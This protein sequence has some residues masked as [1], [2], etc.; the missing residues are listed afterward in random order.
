MGRTKTLQHPEQF[1]KYQLIAELGRSRLGT[2]YKAKIVGLEGF[3]KIVRVKAIDLAFCQ[4]PNLIDPLIAGTQRIVSLSHVNI[5][6]IFDLGQES[7]LGQYYIASEFVLGFDLARSH[8]LFKELEGDVPIEIYARIIS[9][10]AK[11]LDYAHRRKDYNFNSLN[12]AHLNLSPENVLLSFDG[13]VKVNDFGI[14]QAKR[15]LETLDENE[16]IK[17]FKYAAPEIAAGEIGTQQ[18]DIFSLGLMLYELVAGQHPYDLS[19]VE[20][21]RQSAMAA[22][23]VAI[24]EVVDI[25]RA[26][27]TIIDSMIVSNPFGRPDSAADVFEELIAFIYTSTVRTDSKTISLLMQEIRRK[28]RVIDNALTSSSI[29]E[30]SIAD[31]RILTD[32]TMTRQLPVD[33]THGQLP[34]HKLK[35]SFSTVQP[36]LPGSLEE[37]FRDVRAGKGKAVIVSGI[38]GSGRTFLPDRLVDALGWRGN[39]NAYLANV[40]NDDAF[41]PFSSVGNAILSIVAEEP[42]LE[43]AFEKCKLST[44]EKNLINTFRGFSNPFASTLTTLSFDQKVEYLSNAVLKIFRT[45][46]IQGPLVVIFDHIDNVD[47]VSRGVLRLIVEKIPDMSLMLVM[48]SRK[49]DSV[50]EWFDRGNPAALENIHVSGTEPPSLNAL[51]DLTP[52]QARILSTIALSGRFSGQD[53]ITRVATGS[54]NKEVIQTLREL[55]DLSYLRIPKPGTFAPGIAHLETWPSTLDDKATRIDAE[56]MT[57]FTIY[58]DKKG[59][60]RNPTL[61]RYF[62]HAGDQNQFVQFVQHYIWWLKKEGWTEIALLFLDHAILLAEQHSIFGQNIIISFLISRAELALDMSR[63]SE[64]QR[65]LEP[66]KALTE[67]RRDVRNQIRG[68]LLSGRLAMREDDLDEAHTL[69]LQAINTAEKIKDAGLLSDALIEFSGWNHRYGRRTR[70]RE[71]IQRALHIQRE[72]GAKISPVKHASALNLAARIAASEGV[73]TLAENHVCALKSVAKNY[74]EP[75]IS[76]FYL[77]ARADLSF[78][79]QDY[80]NANA[81]LSEARLLAE[82]F[83]LKA[84]QIDLLRRQNMAMLKSHHFELVFELAEQLFSEGEKHGEMR[85]V[86]QARVYTAVAN[87]LTGRD[88]DAVN[89]L[90]FNLKR[91]QKRGIPKDI[92]LIHQLL[93][94]CFDALGNHGLKSEHQNAATVLSEIYGFPT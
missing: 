76:C 17:R 6:Q 50:R 90:L 70:S 63:I 20:S 65:A 41:V 87:C 93:E 27:A 69:F 85:A 32:E 5:A 39:T 88:R 10:V 71:Y 62:L 8:L 3:E 53:E 81:L 67:A 14:W 25:P 30:I 89:E 51:G 7:S 47:I 2:V 83:G 75:A 59:A 13:E 79:R 58:V 86:Q 73:F 82:R 40:S 44:I 49:P 1:G 16:G 4:N 92:Y 18:S 15:T 78:A 80:D 61:I 60:K 19:S 34:T 48:F 72:F 45:Y 26:L 57:R 66:I 24:Q 33:S 77:W 46:S 22:N 74:P 31:I 12:I 21:T 91:A 35:E 38:F 54:S 55:T 64:T 28:E 29:D 56:T 84:M 42:S 52:L 43:T 11:A 37:Y 36:N 94:Q 68:I 23:I 9:E